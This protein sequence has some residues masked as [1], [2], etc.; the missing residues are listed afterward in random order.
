MDALDHWNFRVYVRRW[1]LYRFD[2]MLYLVEI[3]FAYAKS[4]IGSGSPEFNLPLRASILRR[5]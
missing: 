5:G 1:T 2:W 4:T 3:S